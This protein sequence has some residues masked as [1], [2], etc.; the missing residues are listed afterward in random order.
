MNILIESTYAGPISWYQLLFKADAITFDKH[1]HFVKASYRNRCRIASPNG[2]LML[3]VPIEKG[4]NKQQ[5]MSK[6][7]IHNVENWQKMHWQSISTA[8]RRSPFFEYYEDDL[9]PLY[10]TEY[11]SLLKFNSDIFTWIASKLGKDLKYDFSEKYESSTETDKQD[12]RSA[13]HTNPR[14][15]QSATL[16]SPITYHQVFEEKTGFLPN[17]SIFDLLFAEGPNAGSMLEY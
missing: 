10:H 15:D 16:C 3:T 1:E 14:K 6:I 5:L 8:Y 11:N 12:Y 13:I 7:G 17:L 4:R 9:Y 2:V